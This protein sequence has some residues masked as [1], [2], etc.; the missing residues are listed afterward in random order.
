MQK[1]QPIPARRSRHLRT[2]FLLLA[3]LGLAIPWYF[4][5]VYFLSGGSVMPDVFWRDAFANALTTG[6]TADVYLAAVAFSAWVAA[7]RSLGAWRWAYIAACFGVGLAFVM[8]LYLA[9]RLRAG[10]PVGAG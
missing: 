6:I 8:P 3:S 4:N 10:T 9:Q 1:T 2:F 5:T 7:D